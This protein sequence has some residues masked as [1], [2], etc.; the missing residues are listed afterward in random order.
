[1]SRND[2]YTQ[3]VKLHDRSRLLILP[4]AWDAASARVMA[5]AGATAVATTSSGVANALGYPD[6]NKLPREMA[7]DAVARVAQAVDVPVTAD[8]EEGFGET[9]DEVADTVAAIAEAGAIGINIE[10]GMKAPELLAAR[11]E[12]IKARQAATGA[13][14]FVNARID[15]Y[16]RGHATPFEETLRR[17]PLYLKAGADGIFVPAAVKPDEIRRLC[18]EIAA[19]VNLLQ[20]TGLPP[21]SELPALGV[22]RLSAGGALFYA[23]MG[24]AHR[25]AAAFLSGDAG[26]IGENRLPRETVSK[27]FA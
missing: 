25:A 23:A 22:A 2:R 10:D 1:M 13:P 4:N 14:V 27:L 24:L 7:I 16:L 19:P 15:A 26:T 11:I 5:D 12:A 18:A 8:I 20:W 3:F 9:P 6:G 17:V 21:A